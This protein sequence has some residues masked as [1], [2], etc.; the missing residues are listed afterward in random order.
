[1]NI[2]SKT[3]NN[4]L[5]ININGKFDFSVHPDFRRCYKDINPDTIKQVELNMLY[6]SYMDSA[7]LGML[8]LLKEYFANATIRI[9]N[10]N[11]HVRRVL[12]IA[13]FQQKFD[14][15]EQ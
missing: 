11:D 2:T 14:I 3:N 4:T 7:A 5:S 6:V 13:N 1:M 12:D 15:A 9:R 10:C 8:L